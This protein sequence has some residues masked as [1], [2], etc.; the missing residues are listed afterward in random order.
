MIFDFGE[1]FRGKLPMLANDILQKW[2]I[3]TKPPNIY[4]KNLEYVKNK[5]V[6]WLALGTPKSLTGVEK[7]CVFRQ[8]IVKSTERVLKNEQHAE[9]VLDKCCV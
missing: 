6:G 5:K 1:F 7:S 4:A 2:K 9:R 3:Q 8:N